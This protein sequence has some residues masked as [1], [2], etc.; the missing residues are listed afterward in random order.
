R[1]GLTAGLGLSLGTAQVTAGEH[2][3][4]S[5]GIRLATA[6]L[7]LAA[8]A[9]LGWVSLGWTERLTLLRFGQL[10]LAAHLLVAVGPYLVGGNRNGFWQ[11]NR[12]LFLR[13][14]VAGFY[15]FVLWAGLAIALAAIDKL[16]GIRV[17][18]EWYGH[19]AAFLAFV[20][21]PWFFLA[22]VPN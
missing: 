16:L 5:G 3:R 12:F 20:F 10:A 4:W 2:H 13:Y 8:L 17:R 9:A 6:A 18:A 19:L 22:G 15:A 11:Y 21:H 14:L 1:L 7:L